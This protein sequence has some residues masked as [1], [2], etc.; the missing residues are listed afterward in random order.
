MSFQFPLVA[1]K[2]LGYAPDQVDLFVQQARAQFEDPT[3]ETVTASSIRNTEF[4]LVKG[5][6]LISAVDAA[7][8][9]LEDTFAAREIQRQK[10]FRGDFAVN[11]RKARI[12]EIIAGRL[13]RPKRKRFTST[14]WL[15][16]GY[17]RKQV[18]ALCSRLEDHLNRQ[19]PLNIN[20]VRRAIFKTARGGY[21]E[22]QV[23]AFLDRVVELIQIDKNS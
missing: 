3:A 9:R 7:L 2:L 4:D 13:S 17:S 8:D 1:P 16:R 14:G 12:I 5:G 15:L 6:Y 11:D 22:S 18:D 10:L 21:R 20:S 19:A 23:D